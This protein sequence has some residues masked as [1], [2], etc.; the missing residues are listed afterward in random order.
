MIYLLTALAALVLAVT[1]YAMTRAAGPGLALLAMTCRVAEAVSGEAAL[2]AIFF[3]VGSLLFFLAYDPTFGEQLFRS[4]GTAAGTFRLQSSTGNQIGFG[5]SP[6]SYG[7]HGLSNILLVFLAPELF[8]IAAIEVTQRLSN[9]TVRALLA[10]FR[11]ERT[12][13][14]GRRLL[15]P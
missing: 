11:R 10:Q 2:S 8:A 7:R 1:L 4:D 14:F 12:R 13:T 5:N 15:S 3:A 9:K 6:P